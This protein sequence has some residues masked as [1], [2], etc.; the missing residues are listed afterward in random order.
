MLFLYVNVDVGIFGVV[1]LVLVLLVRMV[2]CVV[3]FV[4]GV[5]VGGLLCW[6]WHLRDK[7][8]QGRIETSDRTIET[9]TALSGRKGEK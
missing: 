3:V 1:V 6:R 4:R 9:T 5:R 2:P 7:S 8:S